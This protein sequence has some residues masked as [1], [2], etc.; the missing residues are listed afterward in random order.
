MQF[1]KL[2]LAQDQE[3]I[4][5]VFDIRSSSI[6]VSDLTLR[7][8]LDHYVWL[9]GKIK[10]QLARLQMQHNPPRFGFYKFT[11]DGWILLFPTKDIKGQAIPPGYPLE[12][13]RELSKWFEPAFHAW[14]SEHLD[15]RPAIT[16]ITF[17]VDKGPLRRTTIFQQKEYLAHAII[18]ACRLQAAVGE[19]DQSSGCKALVL[20]SVFNELFASAKDYAI[21]NVRRKLRNIGEDREFD[22]KLILL[23]PEKQLSG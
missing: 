22:C 18:I 13:M 14:A 16:G 11:G 7:N 12:V 1:A 9:V 17:G 10:E 2:T 15:T 8:Q 5:V 23:L 21:A 6:L 19:I 20:N 3:A 4:V